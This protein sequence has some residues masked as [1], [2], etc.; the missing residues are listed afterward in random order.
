M[1]FDGQAIVR[2][3][4]FGVLSLGKY[5]SHVWINE[6]RNRSVCVKVAGGLDSDQ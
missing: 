2:P 3:P 4:F 6:N 1:I 5:I